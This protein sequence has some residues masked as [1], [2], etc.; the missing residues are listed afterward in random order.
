MRR[1]IAP[2]HQEGR[3]FNPPLKFLQNKI[4]EKG[5]RWRFLS[6][7]TIFIAVIAVV[8][9]LGFQGVK[10]FQLR[11]LNTGLRNK[12]SDMVDRVAKMGVSRKLLG[13][14]CLRSVQ[15]QGILYHQGNRSI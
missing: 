5:I 7:I 3:D 8:G 10:G 4:K 12:D 13:E 6:T 2:V 14:V 1:A 15:T 11:S 9:Y